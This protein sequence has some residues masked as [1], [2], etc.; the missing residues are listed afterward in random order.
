MGR[1]VRSYETYQ[2][3]EALAEF[4]MIFEEYGADGSAGTSEAAPSV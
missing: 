1:C 2:M 3:T 4:V